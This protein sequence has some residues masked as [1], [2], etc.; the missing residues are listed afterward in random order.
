MPLGVAPEAFADPFVFGAVDRGGTGGLAVLAALLLV[1]VF[2]R[3]SIWFAIAKKS[4]SDA[5][6]KYSSDMCQQK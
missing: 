4:A 6:S 1:D 5:S 3:L 2:S